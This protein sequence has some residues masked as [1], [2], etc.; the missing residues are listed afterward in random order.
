[1]KQWRASQSKAAL[2]QYQSQWRKKNKEKIYA[3][4]DKQRKRNYER[5]RKI[6]DAIKSHYGCMNPT[7]QWQGEI[8]TYALDFH[9]I[10]DKKCNVGLLVKYKNTLINE[11]KKCVVLCAICHRIETYGNLDVSKI[12][13][14]E[15][16][17][18]L[19]V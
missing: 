19:F 17:E 10:A 18:S 7:C 3:T 11:I 12:P 1:M 6:M 16:D 15:C 4:N 13:T 8:P 5:G 9:H 2:S 14:C